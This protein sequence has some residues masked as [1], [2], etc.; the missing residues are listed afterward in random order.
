MARYD[1]VMLRLDMLGDYGQL[2]GSDL[3]N[4]GVSKRSRQDVKAE[5]H[6]DRPTYMYGET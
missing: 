1:L 5:R 2:A 6:C 3:G 4:V